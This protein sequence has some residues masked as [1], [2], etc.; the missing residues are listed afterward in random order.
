MVFTPFH[1]GERRLLDGG[2]VDPVPVA[3][4]LDDATELTV[5]VDLFGAA[6]APRSGGGRAPRGI[7][8]IALSAMDAMQTTI[9]RLRL[10]A[11][12]PDVLVEIPSTSCGF[13]EFWR[14]KELIALGRERT[15][16]AFAGTAIRAA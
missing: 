3:P 12:A 16:L 10:Q 15:E 4:T 9:A 1:H 11:C 8:D 13:H 2:L 7:I 5:A 6:G 14:S